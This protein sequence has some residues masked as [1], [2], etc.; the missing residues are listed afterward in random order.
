MRKV[1]E[2]ESSLGLLLR[3]ALSYH[4]NYVIGYHRTKFEY[5]EPLVRNGYEQG[6][7]YMYGK[8]MYLTYDLES[9]THIGMTH[10]G[11]TLLKCKIN[12]KNL[13]IFDY[14]ISK[15]VFGNK[16]TL[17]DQLIEHYKLYR[18]LN[19]LPRSL[20]KLS[21]DLEETFDDPLKSAELIMDVFVPTFV[22]GGRCS[23]KQVRGIIFTGSMDGNVMVAYSPDTAIPI[24]FVLTDTNTG[25]IL[26]KW[27]PISKFDSKLTNIVTT[28]AQTAEILLNKF[29]GD[30]EKIHVDKYNLDNFE[31][32]FPWFLQ[33]KFTEV[34]LEITNDKKLIWVDG[35]W[36]SGVWEGEE[37]RKGTWKKGKW[38]QGIFNGEWLYGN[39]VNGTFESGTWYDGLWT[40]GI[41]SGKGT[42]RKGNIKKG[43]RLIISND[44]PVNENI[45]Y[46]IQHLYGGNKLSESFRYDSLT[47]IEQ[48]DLY[49]SFKQSYEKAVGASWDQDKFESRSRNWLFFGSKKGGIATRKQ[50]SGMYKLVATFGSPKEIINS[51][52]EMISE[53]GRDPIWGVMT[54]NL[55]VMLEKRSNGQFKQPPKLFV[56]ILI[57][58]IKNIFGDVIHSVEND[59]GI[60]LDT[61]AGLMTKYFI[62]NNSYYTQ[63]LDQMENRADS[64]PIP[65]PVVKILIGI[66]K[67][68]I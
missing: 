7:G 34:Q 50:N 27:Q 37:F 59:G 6:S 58:K 68:F 48:N 22:K 18:S 67:K 43:G 28:R 17:Q 53:I 56:K 42:W 62:A 36:I 2:K 8:G 49:A 35:I 23:I 25:E 32:D 40:H 38:L 1:K 60:V 57:P 52:N 44:A 3:E 9:Q 64:L 47:P 26:G 41:W 13:L 65:K 20:F 12:P 46:I 51:F 54:D 4:N 11:N 21:K 39:F 30:V 61:P 14:N 66:L 63:M 10:Y 15:V 19:Q 24:E 55:A 31:K 29:H 5:V 16:Y 45:D 33:A